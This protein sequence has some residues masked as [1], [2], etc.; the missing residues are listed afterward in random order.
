MSQE[1]KAISSNPIATK[2]RKSYRKKTKTKRLV[3]EID[4]PKLSLQKSDWESSSEEE[5]LATIKIKESQKMAKPRSTEATELTCKS[6]K[7]AKSQESSVKTD[8][9][10]ADRKN[11][12]NFSD[13]DNITSDKD[14]S[15]EEITSDGNNGLRSRKSRKAVRTP[16][17][18]EHASPNGADESIAPEQ[19]E[20]EF[21]PQ[22]ITQNINNALVTDPS[23]RHMSQRAKDALVDL[24]E[25]V[26]LKYQLLL[27]QLPLKNAKFVI[28]E[29]PVVH[30]DTKLDQILR[31]MTDL[32]QKVERFSTP[33]MTSQPE[34]S[35]HAQN[36]QI[37]SYAQALKAPKSTL[38]VRPKAISE[39]PK[40]VLEK[41]KKLPC[42]EDVRITKVRIKNNNIEVRCNNERNKEMLHD[43]INT[44]L[45]EEVVVSDKR[46]VLQRLMALN[47]PQHI[48]ETQLLKALGPDDEHL[49]NSRAISKFSARREGHQHWVFLCPKRLAQQILQ[50]G[51][52][53]TGI[54]RVR[55]KKHIRMTRCKNCQHLNHHYT[56]ECECATFCAKCAGDH[57]ADKCTSKKHKCVNCHSR[58][59]AEKENHDIPEDEKEFLDTAHAADSSLCPTYQDILNERL[60][61]TKQKN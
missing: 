15:G 30:D 14:S 35:N 32:E 24:L 23:L 52:I 61:T 55:V 57:T 8:K 2:K 47:V 4:T 54:Q 16:T 13:S 18:E 49:K 10:P 17:P 58:N 36:P 7:K 20:A 27:K 25:E 11:C 51:F 46:P 39:P 50:V 40:A 43:I 6:T 19:D 42:P 26:E 38:I 31:R 56:H 48:S 33:A 1:Q 9:L 34:Q 22:R 12:H 3:E 59:V 44:K 28:A 53:Y 37:Q 5:T 45:Q 60:Y 21:L 41:L 29:T